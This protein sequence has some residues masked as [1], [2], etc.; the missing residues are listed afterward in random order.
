MNVLILGG[1]SQVGLALARALAARHLEHAVLS[2]WS[3]SLS[4]AQAVQPALAQLSPDF[5][6]HCPDEADWHC[7]S[8][9]TAGKLAAALA[10]A[11][12][13][14]GAALVQLSCEQVFDGRKTSAYTESDVPNPQP[15]IGEICWQMEEQVRRHCPHHLIVRTSWLFGPDGDNRL[16]RLLRQA[17][18][19]SQ[20][21][22]DAGERSCPTSAADVARVI[23]AMLQQ[24]DC[25]V[26]PPLWGTYH[27]AGSDVANRVIFAETV[28]KAAKS[29]LDVSVERVETTEPEAERIINTELSSRKVLNVFGIKQHPWRRGVQDSL[30]QIYES[31]DA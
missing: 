27:Y 3:E 11:C 18:T 2:Q 6:V 25:Q 16:T 4:D 8:I 29:Y 12:A 17:T 19:H 1:Q 22:L 7:L 28:L 31:A 20:L 9:D 13:N 24:I 15:G 10:Q 26:D 23:V 14:L 5:V 30:K 21:T